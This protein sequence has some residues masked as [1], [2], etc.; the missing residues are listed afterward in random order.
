VG[1][2]WTLDAGGWVKKCRKIK[3]IHFF[4]FFSRFRTSNVIEQQNGGFML[5]DEQVRVLEEINARFNEELQQQIDGKLITKEKAFH[6]YEL[7]RPGEILLSAGI[8]DLPIEVTAKTLAFK[9]SS[10]YTHPF[11]LSE[12]K[13]LPKAIQDP[14]MIFDS[15]T[16]DDSKVIL[17]ELKSKGHNFVVAMEMCR[18]VGFSKIAEINSIRSIYPKEY[19]KDILKWAE[20]GFLKYVN[21]NKTSAFL[22]QLRYQFPQTWTKNAEASLHNIVKYFKNSK[23]LNK[24]T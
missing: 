17:T 5:E 8:L 18:K 24:K 11:E 6:I 3:K 9:S 23:G 16:E 4:G 22:T 15:Y 14:I 10:E 13:S 21:R 19:V 12:L 1:G 7:G 20:E 2:S